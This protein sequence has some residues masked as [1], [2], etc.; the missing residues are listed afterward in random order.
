M[1]AKGQGLIY[2]RGTLFWVQYYVRGKRYRETSGS[3][4]RADAVRLLKRRTAEA[5]SGRPF[6][7]DIEKTTLPELVEMVRNDYQANGRRLRAVHAP[8]NHLLAYFGKDCRAMDVSSDRV[9][10]YIANRQQAGAANATINRS[11]AALKRGFVLAERAGKA[12]RRPHI[13][14]LEERNRRK[15]FFEQDQIAALLNE[16]PEELRTLIETASITGWR[17]TSELATRQKRHLDLDAGWLRLDP[18]ESKNQE[19]RNF[20]LTPELRAVLERQLEQTRTLEVATGQVIPW[21]FHRD[22]Q[23]IGSFR[24]TWQSA[25][26]RAKLGG[27]IPHDFRR[28]A[29]RNLE[30]AG[31]SRSSAMAMVGH[32]TQSIYQRYAIADEASLKRGR[33]EAVRVPPS[34]PR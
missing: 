1:K 8:L 3:T 33:G 14:M 27:K 30:R 21:L 4:N 18:G 31:V 22:C 6:G 13:E 29:V 19:G 25:C 26:T 7:H 15:G 9:T 5:G 12:A 23:P 28:T 17:I 10:A 32:K 16:L 20:P 34:R 24:K 2:Q 11:L